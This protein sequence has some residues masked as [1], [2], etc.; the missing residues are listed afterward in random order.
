MTDDLYRETVITE[1]RRPQNYGP[2]TGAD[3]ITSQVNP[4]CGDSVKVYVKLNATKDK[5]EDLS[6]E[7]AGCVVSMASMS[8]L[9]TKVKG[10]ALR[11]IKQLAAQELKQLL[12]VKDITPSREKCM[13]MGLLAIKKALNNIAESKK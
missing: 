1:A 4:A 13:M 10:M 2:L 9:S 8:F 11:K 12:G 3:V 6:W 5:I 7:G